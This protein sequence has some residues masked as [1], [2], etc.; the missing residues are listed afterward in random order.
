MH[1]T[2]DGLHLTGI[3][4][5]HV[6]EHLHHHHTVGRT[7]STIIGKRLR[8]HLV[9][10]IITGHEIHIVILE[11]DT[12]D[13][14]T[15]TDPDLV[16]QILRDR[17][18][19]IVQ[20]TVTTGNH[21]RQLVRFLAEELQALVRSHPGPATRVTEGT[22]HIPPL[23][24]RFRRAVSI[25]HIIEFT[26]TGIIPAIR[27]E[28][29][30]KRTGIEQ[31][32]TLRTG[33]HATLFVE[34]NHIDIRFQHPTIQQFQFVVESLRT[35]LRV[36]GHITE[37]CGDIEQRVP[38]GDIVQMRIRLIDRGEL[39]LCHVETEQ[40]RLLF[41]VTDLIDI[42][43]VVIEYGRTLIALL[44]T[45]I[46]GIQL[47]LGLA[48]LQIL[49]LHETVVVEQ[50]QETVTIGLHILQVLVGTGAIGLLRRHGVEVVAIEQPHHPVITN[51]QVVN[52]LREA[53]LQELVLDRGHKL[54]RCQVHTGHRLPVLQPQVVILIKI[55]M[56]VATIFIQGIDILFG[57]ID[58]RKRLS[59]EEV[60][61]THR[62]RHDTARP[63]TFDDLGTVVCQTV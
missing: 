29:D 20:Q 37:R 34:G 22:V 62:R 8:G 36:I 5:Q 17:M 21:L 45:I 25:H 61:L 15:R 9:V 27:P 13:T 58:K 35:R 51:E 18:D 28:G 46:I 30:V 2:A 32:T 3:E 10:S 40:D 4:H 44:H 43:A 53:E 55:E 39:T 52:S 23:E 48:S 57:S 16:I 42:V 1:V 59:V 11:H 14:I 60:D 54:L 31:S 56:V 50:Q 41:T 26:G 38:F 12:R 7:G 24:G 47:K 33:P 19:Y 49:G 6:I 63:C